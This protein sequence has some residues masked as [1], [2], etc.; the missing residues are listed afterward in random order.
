MRERG[1]DAQQAIAFLREAG[2]AHERDSHLE[3]FSEVHDRNSSAMDVHNNEIGA[4]IG[5]QLAVQDAQTGVSK[6]DGERALGMAV[7]Q[8][9]VD[10]RTV[11]LDSVL[12][13]PRRSRASDIAATDPAGRIQRGLRGELIMR[14]S[15]PDAPGY[16]S[17]LVDGEVDLSRPYVRL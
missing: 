10:G 11:V 15:P 3:R 8:A 1:L 4:A 14:T 6:L 13:S 17:P 9:I 2:A 7:M 5:A 16:P 12:S